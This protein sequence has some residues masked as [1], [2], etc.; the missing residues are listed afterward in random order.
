MPRKDQIIKQLQRVGLKANQLTGQALLELFYDIY[1]GQFVENLATAPLHPQELL[2]SL[3]PPQPMTNQTTFTNPA[4]QVNLATP[5]G[6]SQ[7][8]TSQASKTHPF[9]VEELEA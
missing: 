6:S 7:P 4:T 5:E 2:V 3:K 9:V 1:N 8:L